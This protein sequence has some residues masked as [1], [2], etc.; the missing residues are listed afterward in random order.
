MALPAAD[1]EGVSFGGDVD[2]GFRSQYNFRGFKVGDRAPSLDVNFIF[3][4]STDSGLTLKAGGWYINPVEDDNDEFGLYAFL[5]APVADFNFSLGGTFF[6]FPESGEVTGEFGATASYSVANYVDLELAWWSDVKA[7]G[8]PGD[9]LQFGHYIEFS[10]G[11]SFALKDWLG[12]EMGAGISYGIDYYGVDGLNHA[13]GTIGFPMGFSETATLTPYVAGT[14][15][16]EGLEDIG[17][18]DHFL[19]GISLSVGF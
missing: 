11:Q 15:A 13:F 9:E 19:A 6:D 2:V 10:V 12:V 3:P 4:I 18:T 17:E 16:L 1:V 14:L 5:A 8:A 7:G